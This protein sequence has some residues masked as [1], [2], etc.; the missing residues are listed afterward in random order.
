[1]DDQAVIRTYGNTNLPEGTPDRPLVTFAL[2]AYNQEKYIREAVEGAFSQTYSPLEIILSDDC[3]SDR[4]FEIMEEMARVYRG[5]HQVK[6][7]KTKI[8]VGTIDHIL[9]VA[10]KA[11]GELIVVAA[12]DDV[13]NRKRVEELAV[14][15]LSSKAEVIQSHYSEFCDSEGVTNEELGQR[16][17]QTI[18]RWFKN[19]DD[20][21]TAEGDWPTIIG[22]TAAYQKSV[23]DGV[24]QNGFK[25]LNED[26]LFTILANLFQYR[27]ETIQRVLVNHR[28]HSSNVSSDQNAKGFSAVKANELSKARFASSS[29][30]FIEFYSAYL[31]SS[32][33]KDTAVFAKCVANNLLEDLPLLRLHA[34][35]W[36]LPPR[37]RFRALLSARV[38]CIKFVVPRLLGLELFTILKIVFG[39]V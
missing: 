26:A 20:L 12:G 38:D 24:P 37:E 6:V 11:A 22:C 33:F 3:S 10:A 28:R 13:S 16:A 14:R 27:I 17:S 36:K 25:C 30:K 35:F 32:S 31:E 18:E 34:S 15:W 2:F 23:F 39:R 5:P 7:N 19:C 1:M 29:V 4:T 8:N 21:K 9:Q